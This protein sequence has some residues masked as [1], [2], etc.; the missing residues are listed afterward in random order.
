MISKFV[1]LT[2]YCVLEYMMTPLGYI[3]AE[4]LNTNF[5]SV[6]NDNLGIYQIYNTDAYTTLTRNTRGN[7]VVPIGGGRLIHIQ[8]T[9]IPLYTHYDPR[10]TETQVQNSLTHTQV[11][12]TM[13]FH[14]ASGFNFTEVQNVILGARLKM[15]NIKEVQIANV[16]V[17]AET[18]QDLLTFNIRPLFLANTVYDRYVDIKVPSA[19]YLDQ[20]FDAF[21]PQSLEYVM[22]ECVGLIKNAP[23]TVSL[24]E[25]AYEDYFADN[26]TLYQSYKVSNYHEG[27]VSQMNEFDNLG[28]VI[29]EA[30]DGDY[31]E[32]FATWNDAFPDG[33]IA[34]LNSKGADQNWIIVH[35]LQVYEQVGSAQVPSGNFLVYQ[36]NNFD[37]PLTYRPILKEAGFAVSMSIDYTL[38]LLNKTTGEQVVRTGSMSLFNPNKYGKHLIKLELASKPQSMHVYNKI[39]K[40]SIEAST[41]FIGKPK[42]PIPVS[43]ATPTTITQIKEVKVGVPTFYKQA[44]IRISHKNALLKTTDSTSEVIYGQGEMLLPIDPTDNYIKFSVYEADQKDSGKQNFANLNN[45]SKFILNFGKDGS[46]T[47]NSLTDPS[48]ENPSKGQIAFRIPKDQSKKILQS[49]DNLVYIS[50]IAEDG[51]ETLLYTGK[52]I[53]STEY[54]SVLMAAETAKSALLNDPESVIAGLRTSIQSLQAENESLK[55]KIVSQPAKSVVNNPVENHQTIN[56]LASQVPASIVNTLTNTKAETVVKNSITVVPTTTKKSGRFRK[57]QAPP[58]D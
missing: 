19:A 58:L 42:G 8:L 22:T 2:D 40:K 11:F 16:L 6:K 17:N 53:S 9:D 51:T 47:Y 49:T 41:L 26:G 33:L 45:N 38:R 43:T 37:V 50:L 28:A 24:A 46:L 1:T 36:E 7:S 13:R 56:S 27:T 39:V 34:Y 12:D 54:S 10:I 48:V 29:Q 20:N 5:Y 21:G 3:S 4:I 14:F 57:I 32:F 35:Q 44:N 15:N 30:S 23:I 55:S 18:Y 52:W 31:I 25:A